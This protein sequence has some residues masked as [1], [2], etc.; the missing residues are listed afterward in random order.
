VI[1]RPCRARY[2]DSVRVLKI[3]RACQRHA[4]YIVAMRFA[5]RYHEQVVFLR[6]FSSEQ[7]GELLNKCIAVVYTPD[8]EHFGIVPVEG[9]SLT[10]LNV[11]LQC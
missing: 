2:A 4:I 1:T 10:Y 5:A 11:T 9:V 6:S 8:R 7:R 3:R